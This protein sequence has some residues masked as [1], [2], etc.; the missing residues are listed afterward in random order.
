ML[1]GLW[2]KDFHYTNDPN[3][4][5]GVRVLIYLSDVPPKGGGT[6]VVRGS[7]KL[8]RHFVRGLHEDEPRQKMSLLRN[9]FN[10]SHPWLQRLTSKGDEGADRVDYF[11]KRDHIIGSVPVRVCELPGA[12]QR[13]LSAASVARARTIAERC[14]RASVHA[15]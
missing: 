13:C 7:H 12:M 14:N 10:A 9:R 4:L 1:S 2:H 8:V 6:V 11:M 15:R 5:F 3:S